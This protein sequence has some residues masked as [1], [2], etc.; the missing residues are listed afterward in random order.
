MG[1]GH[2]FDLIRRLERRWG[3]AAQGLG[4][5]A[6]VLDVPAGS[7]L[8]VSTDTSVE[9]VHFRR[10][11]LTTGEIGYRSSVAALSDL[12][13]MAAE[14]LGMVVALTLPAD[15]AEAIDDIGNGIADASRTA[16]CPIV[17][18]D[19]TR[20]DQLSLTVT[21]LGFSVHPVRRRGARP[22]QDIVVTGRLGGPGAA[23]RALSEGRMPEPTHRERFARPVPRLR[24]AGWLAQAGATA[25]IDISDGLAPEARHLAAA[26]GLTM[27]IDLDVLPAMAGL[28]AAQ[29]ALSGEEYELLATVPAGPDLAAFAHAFGIPLTRIG[30]VQ[31]GEATAT[32][33]RGG[34]RVDLA[35]GYDHFSP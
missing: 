15:L 23:L 32:F 35:G 21:V 7:R 6:A 11:W 33:L 31:D 3:P 12:A 30:A 1:A 22:G 20:G 28:D 8:V 16:R 9:G 27:V 10:D 17:G 24:E 18:G 4:D 29:A 2:E 25:M 14:P 13:A 19:L 5:D 26:S 34:D